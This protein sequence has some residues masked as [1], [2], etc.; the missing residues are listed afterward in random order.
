M[1]FRHNSDTGFNK[2]KDTCIDDCAFVY[3]KDMLDYDLIR[4]APAFVSKEVID[5]VVDH[6]KS[7]KK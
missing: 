3:Y 6:W 2:Y 1:T 5:N 4:I 7:S